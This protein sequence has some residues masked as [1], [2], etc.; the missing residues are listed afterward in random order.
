VVAVLV[1]LALV[2][3]LKSVV[4]NRLHSLLSQ[5]VVFLRL[6]ELQSCRDLHILL[7]LSLGVLRVERVALIK[8]F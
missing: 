6:S 2:D 4:V 8:L 5:F 1:D 3:E 7:N